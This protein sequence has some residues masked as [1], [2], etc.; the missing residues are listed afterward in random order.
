MKAEQVPGDQLLDLRSCG[1]HAMA[2]TTAVCLYKVVLTSQ[3]AILTGAIL[4]ITVN[5]CEVSE[6]VAK[7]ETEPWNN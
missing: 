7:Q 4:S 1:C 6:C 2:V 5:K 3:E